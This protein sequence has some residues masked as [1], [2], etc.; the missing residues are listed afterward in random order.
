MD[1]I[2]SLDLLIIIFYFAVVM[3]IGLFFSRRKGENTTGYFLAGRNVGWIAIGA[4]LFAT[5]ISSEHFIGLAGSGAVSGL[6]VGN[7]E[8]MATIFII[9]MGWIFVPLY[10]KSGVFTIPEFIG[11]RF[12]NSSR[13]YLAALSIVAYILTKLTVTLFAGGLLLEEVLGWDMYTSTVVMVVLTGIYTI[14]GG[15]G[16]VIYTSVIQAF[17]LIG[18]AILLTMLGLNEVGGFSGLQQKLPADFF[19]MFKSTSDADFPWTGI[20]FGA[21]I[22]GVWYWCT[23]QYIVQ[24]ALS[25]KNINHARSGTIL[26][27]FLKILPVFILVIPGLIAAVLF[28]GIAGNQAYPRLLASSLLP[29]GLK[30][31]VVAGLLAALMSSLASCFNSTSTL[32]TMDFYRY[33]HPEASDRKLVLVGRLTTTVMVITGV[34]WIPLTKIISSNM[35]V[36]LQSIQAYISPPIA[37]LFLVGV[38]WKKMNSTGAIYSLIIGSIVGALRLILEIFS[39]LGYLSFPALD[40]FVSMNYLH[41]AILLFVLSSGILIVGSLYSSKTFN[42]EHTSTATS[43]NMGWEISGSG[44][45]GLRLVSWNGV[46]LTLSVILI[47]VLVGLWGYFF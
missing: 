32:F 43:I 47:L 31:L 7:F 33:F 24:R 23:D 26:T 36:Y 39:K 5:N 45:P 25:A 41:F 37:A 6:A 10:L 14:V 3:G 29:V 30:G 20:I 38:F 9:L 34:L 44:L 35:Y 12:D 1:K 17:F 27:A 13:M 46:N 40:W 11:K 22:L 19:C 2:A 16:A 21:P 15:L 28:P 8:W 18:G 42:F 4:S